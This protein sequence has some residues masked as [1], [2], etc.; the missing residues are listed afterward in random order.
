VL[1]L[2]RTLV[3]RVRDTSRRIRFRSE[4]GW[5]IEA[6]ELIDALPAFDDLPEDVL[7]DLAGRVTLVPVRPGHVVFRQGDHAEAFFV[8]RKGEVAVEDV[9]PGTGDTRVLR[10]LK[11]G[12]S[13][14][15]LGLLGSAT[16]SATVRAVDDVE[17][18]RVDKEAFDRLLA[19]EI[20]APNFGPTMQSFA[21]LRALAPFRALITED[22]EQ[23]LRHGSWI[24]LVP[25]QTAITEGEPG[26]AFYVVGSGQ[27]EVIRD[28][29]RR[30]TLGP[31]DHFGEV[32]LLN[33]AP[34]N[35]TVVARTPV[36][37]FR[38]DREG[39]DEVVA[40]TF[41]RAPADRAPDRTMEH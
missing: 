31:G 36:R 3:K 32:A 10:T 26:D 14:G 29:A 25:N 39:F 17:L 4:R 6:A 18:F 7:S 5:R 28:G 21:E 19:D 11:G 15:E 37:A 35:A 8:V 16:R 38:L 13:F 23:L 12:E 30:A 1:T 2:T 9:D 41:R 40:Q 33:D 22:L 34:R 27:L 24:D 20:D